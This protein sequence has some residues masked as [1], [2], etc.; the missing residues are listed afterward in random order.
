MG[1]MAK[2]F[3]CSA[4][5]LAA[6]LPMQ[7]PGEE[8]P[9]EQAPREDGAPAGPAPADSSAPKAA[10]GPEEPSLLESLRPKA[11]LLLGVHADESEEWA[12]RYGVRQARL[13][14]RLRQ[15][16]YRVEVEAD[17]AESSILNDAW[18]ELRATE[19]LRFRLGR[20]KEPFGRFRLA[21]S[22]D[23]PLPDRPAFAEAAQDLGFGGRDL[24]LA[25][26]YDLAFFE[27]HAGAFQGTGVGAEAP[28]ETGFFRVTA[29]PLSFLEL[30]TSVARRAVFDGGDGDAVGLDARIEAWGFVALAEWQTA[31]DLSRGISE[32]GAALLVAR[33][34]ALEEK[35][36]LEPAVGAEALAGS[37]RGFA[38]ALGLG[39]EDGFVVRLGVRR[40]PEPDGDPAATALAFQV[41]VQR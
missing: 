25:I 9:R 38:A 5:L 30:G 41:G 19:D 3:G 24:G 4:L 17:L 2:A 23:L 32:R 20:F 14:I 37:G 10:D 16:L 39:I 1:G 36:W 18:I 22:W 34:F 11:R 15:E 12:R 26:R 21:S 8:P 28:Q 27:L 6:A 13:G 29:A 31:S 40:A 35:L 33:R 7:A